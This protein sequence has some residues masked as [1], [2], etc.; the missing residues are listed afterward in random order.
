MTF[1]FGILR[2]GHRWRFQ[3][4]CLGLMWFC[5]NRHLYMNGI[6][7]CIFTHFCVRFS[8]FKKIIQKFKNFEVKL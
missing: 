6:K 7:R 8:Y 2:P 3:H 5:Q 1:P 4:M